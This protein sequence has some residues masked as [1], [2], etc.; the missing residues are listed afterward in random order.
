[1]SELPSPHSPMGNTGSSP[2]DRRHRGSYQ[3]YPQGILQD[4]A[5][6]IPQDLPGYLAEAE[7]AAL[8]A[9]T[10]SEPEMPKP[11]V[12]AGAFDRKLDELIL[13]WNSQH[14]QNQIKLSRFDVRYCCQERFAMR[15][16]SEIALLV[17]QALEIVAPAFAMNSG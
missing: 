15:D 16:Q 1:M 17:H 13:I 12:D 7:A 3:G 6:D 2:R 11:T 5:Q 8:A 14:G 10:A 9:L 4:Y